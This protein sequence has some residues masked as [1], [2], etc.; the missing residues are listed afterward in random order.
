[1]K[2]AAKIHLL[3]LIALDKLLD[4]HFPVE[5]TG[6]A[7]FIPA[8]S[9]VPIGRLPFNVNKTRQLSSKVQLLNVFY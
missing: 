4:K 9:S 8:T 2:A 5:L 6:S 1:V 3:E 7:K